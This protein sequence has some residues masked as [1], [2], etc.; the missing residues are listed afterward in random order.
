[1]VLNHRLLIPCNF[2]PAYKLEFLYRTLPYVACMP[3]WVGCVL[4]KYILW[5]SFMK[6]CCPHK[7]GWSL[8]CFSP[9][10]PSYGDIYLT[11]STDSRLCLLFRV[12]F[13]LLGFSQILVFLSL[14]PWQFWAP[15]PASV[16]QDL[17]P[18]SVIQDQDPDL[19]YPTP[20][21]TL[22]LDSVVC[23]SETWGAFAG[24]HHG[25]SPLTLLRL[26]LSYCY[27]MVWPQE[28]NPLTKT[29]SASAK[30][31]KASQGYQLLQTI[32]AHRTPREPLCGLLSPF[33]HSKASQM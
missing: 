30:P 23:S 28:L 15:D 1:M 32:S 9:T 18:A 3:G 8:Q 11:R 5:V 2:L 19:S 26:F 21:P 4:K 20:S 10:C 24:T 16:L 14:S 17:G 33:Y 13:P 12:Y 27:S 7:W 25:Q 6:F 22:P 29:F 31:F